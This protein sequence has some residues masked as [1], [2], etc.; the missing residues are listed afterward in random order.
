MVGTWAL[1][2]ADVGKE[3]QSR[4]LS[5]RVSQAQ[6]SWLSESFRESLELGQIGVS[7]NLY[8]SQG[9]SVSCLWAV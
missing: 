6:C 5:L 9:S 1:T 4:I 8:L 3:A 2:M 7:E